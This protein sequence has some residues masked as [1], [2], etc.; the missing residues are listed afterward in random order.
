MACWTVATAAS[1]AARR[2]S[3]SMSPVVNELLGHRASNDA[4]FDSFVEREADRL[5][6]AIPVVQG[7][8]VHVHPDDRVGLAAVEAACETHRIIERI[9][10]VVEAVGDAFA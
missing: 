6:A 9:L 2:W 3:S 10:S 8:V 5:P 7:P 4:C 1:R